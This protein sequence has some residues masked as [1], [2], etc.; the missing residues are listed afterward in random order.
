[1][2]RK[3]WIALTLALLLCLCAAGALAA[4]TFR[5]ETKTLTMNE[6][7]TAQPV[8]IRDG[9]PAEDGTMT[10]T[11]SNKKVLSVTPDGQITAL[12]KG[13][14][15]VKATLKIGKRSFSASS[16]SASTADAQRKSPR[17]T[18]STR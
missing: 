14:A 18:R 17:S 16:I 12:G 6:G 5:F 15:N 7:E 3:L 1:M 10:Y 11:V 4:D 13:Q 8:L 9:T 2:R